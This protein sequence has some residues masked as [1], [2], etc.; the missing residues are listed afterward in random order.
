[1][2]NFLS[3]SNQDFLSYE[4]FIV[5]EPGSG[6][7]DP[8]D[9][10]I[11]GNEVPKLFE[12]ILEV[13]NQG[14]DLKSQIIMNR[15]NR[16]SMM[17]DLVKEYDNIVISKFLNRVWKRYSYFSNLGEN[18]LDLQDFLRVFPEYKK[19]DDL[20]TTRM[21]DDSEGLEL[22][23]EEETVETPASTEEET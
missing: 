8:T 9:V 13:M 10:L 11:K 4:N 5:F 3:Q 21:G 23:G 20:L 22:E 16:I 17:L 2:I 1:M 6:R 19:R 7:I 18:L 15:L 12:K 14:S